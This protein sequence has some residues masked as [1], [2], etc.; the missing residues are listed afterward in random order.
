MEID[1]ASATC[2][3]IIS[4]FPFGYLKENYLSLEKPSKLPESKFWVF[5]RKE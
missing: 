5:Q 1:E 2:G 4:R 3:E